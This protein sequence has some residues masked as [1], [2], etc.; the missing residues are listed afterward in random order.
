[1]Q[2]KWS[3]LTSKTGPI[4][5]HTGK[6]GFTVA[7]FFELEKVLLWAV[8]GVCSFRGLETTTGVPVAV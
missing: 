6:G 3:V 8:A 2:L 5:D 7:H 4:Q 1:M